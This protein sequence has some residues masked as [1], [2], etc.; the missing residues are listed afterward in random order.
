MTW[1]S[2][3]VAVRRLGLCLR[4]RNSRPG[5][6]RGEAPRPPTARRLAHGSLAPENHDLSFGGGDNARVHAAFGRRWLQWLPD[7]RPARTRLIPDSAA[8]RSSEWQRRGPVE[9]DLRMVE[10]AQALLIASFDRLECCQHNRDA[11]INTHPC[12]LLPTASRPGASR[13]V[14]SADRLGLVPGR[15]H[16][17]G[18]GLSK[19]RCN[20]ANAERVSCPWPPRRSSARGSAG[21]FSAGLPGGAVPAGPGR[22]RADQGPAGWPGAGHGG[23]VGE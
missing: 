13:T 15:A 21:S 20:A 11:V 10:L 9:L 4:A 17:D 7:L 1:D 8:R 16:R 2:A 18:R 23:G 14:V 6:Q 22:S 5:P 3:V 19:M 12:L